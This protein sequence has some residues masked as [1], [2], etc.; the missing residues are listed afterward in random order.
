MENCVPAGKVEVDVDVFA[1]VG[2]PAPGSIVL[3]RKQIYYI[4]NFLS[5]TAVSGT[6]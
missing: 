1:A 2:Q 4:F 3:H 6:E 5:C